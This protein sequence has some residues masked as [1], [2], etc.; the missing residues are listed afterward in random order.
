MKGHINQWTAMSLIAELGQRVWYPVS[1]ERLDIYTQFL[2]S[3]HCLPRRHRTAETTELM[4]QL[5]A[6]NV[7]VVWFPIGCYARREQS[8][9]LNPYASAQKASWKTFILVLENVKK[10]LITSP[11][12]WLW[13]EAEKYRQK[14]SVENLKALSLE[15]CK[16]QFLYEF[17]GKDTYLAVTTLRTD[18]GAVH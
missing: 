7:G 6:A 10:R 14:F 8:F 9:P 5:A 16:L 4:L 13:Q 1:F 15:F 18:L 11:A 3:G 17:S 2:V 12:F